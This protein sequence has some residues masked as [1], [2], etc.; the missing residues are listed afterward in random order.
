MQIIFE[1]IAPFMAITRKIVMQGI[2]ARLTLFSTFSI[3]WRKWK[4]NH[5]AS[6]RYQKGYGFYYGS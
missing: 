1:G 5:H 2:L 6:S 4:T 3:Q